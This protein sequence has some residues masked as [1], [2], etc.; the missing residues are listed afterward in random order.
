MT[1]VKICGLTTEADAVFAQR[2]GARFL[3]VILAGGP[4]LLDVERA[5][6]VLGVRRHGVSRVAVFADRPVA[7]L[8]SIS[9]SLD[10]DVLQLHGEPS[11]ALIAQLRSES[12]RAVWP[13]VRIAGTDLPSEARELA[14]AAGTLVLD[15]KVVGQLG[16]TGVALDWSG[17][18]D[19]VESLRV[20]VPGVQLVLAGGLR[21]SN[22]AKAI[23]L[24]NPEV[25]DV[26]SGVESAPGVK[27]P[28]AV[29]RFVSAVMAAK[30]TRR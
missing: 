11:A 16:G 3:G 4:R 5:R 15:A 23:A 7:E 14:A 19:S 9:E 29:E 1:Q 18:A 27:D 12:S 20:S 28:L 30:G 22:V 13:V 10:L 26:S 8:L 25:V 21:A 24:L 17:L 6:D 2:A